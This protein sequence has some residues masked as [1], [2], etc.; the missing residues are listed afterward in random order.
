VNEVHE[1]TGLDV[2][3]LTL[4]GVYKNMTRGIVALVFHCEIIGGEA[5]PTAEAREVAW[6]TSDQ[7]AEHMSDAYS[8][9]LL[10]ALDATT[11][12]RAH[13][14]STVVS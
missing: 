1:E 13:D 14:G 12:V 11:T 9:R 10:D 7:L 8:V 3:P 6:L 5:R 4:T 2:K